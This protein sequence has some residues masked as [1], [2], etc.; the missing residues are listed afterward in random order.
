MRASCNFLYVSIESKRQW[1]FTSVPILAKANALLYV[2]V[3][4]IWSL[5]GSEKLVE[6][7]E[8]VGMGVEERRGARHDAAGVVAVEA[9]Q[10][11]HEAHELPSGGRIGR[12]PSL[13]INNEGHGFVF[14]FGRT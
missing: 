10:A 9:A 7:S 6:A 8:E 11:H 1:N 13:D 2:D 12:K 5:A 4:R 14:L 3:L